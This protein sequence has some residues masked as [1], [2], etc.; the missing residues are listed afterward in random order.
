MEVILKEDI[1]G[2]GFKN[3][4]V[5][6][7][8]GYGR[9]FLIPTGKAVIASDSARK[10]LA[11]VLKQQA[12]KLA[13]LK[14]KA[15]E[16]AKVLEGVKVEIAARVSATGVCYGSVTAAMVSEALAK[17]G[18]EIDRKLIIMKDIKKL[19]EY[20]ATVVF[21]KEV[22]VELPVIVVAENADELKA[23]KERQEQ[24]VKEAA[25]A[26]APKAEEEAEE[27]EAPVEEE[28]K[29]E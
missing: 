16:Q 14:A 27:A 3:D 6:V 29:A 22:Q 18:I 28:A 23:E 12:H 13:A 24:I 4:I 26:T 8:G 17:K 11:E 15:E 9:N 19:G 7:K 20:V 1:I 25:V 2:L 10:C 5:T 21:H